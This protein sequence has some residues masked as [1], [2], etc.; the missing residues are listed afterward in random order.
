MI[1]TMLGV[2]IMLP[3]LGFLANGSIAVFRKRTGGDDDAGTA[4]NPLVSWIGPGV[5]MAAFGVAIALFLDMQR[6]P[7]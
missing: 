6:A 2:L 1:P 4:R 7:E 5:I 3:I